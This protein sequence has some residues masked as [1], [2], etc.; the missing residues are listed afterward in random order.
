M[1][2]EAVAVDDMEHGC[3]HGAGERVAAEGRAV[4]AG[5]EAVGERLEWIGVFVLA[6]GRYG[7]EGAPVK[8]A[9]GRDDLERA[10]AV[11]CAPLAS[12]LD[13][14]LVRLRT[15]VAEEDAR[16]EG[17]LDQAAREL[18]LGLR[19]VEV[20]GVD[21]LGRLPGDRGCDVGVRVAEKV[22]GDP[23]HQVEVLA[24]GVVVEHAAAAADEGDG[25]PAPGLH[26]VAIGERGRGHDLHSP[27]ARGPRMLYPPT[28]PP[29]HPVKGGLP[30]SA[31]GPGKARSQRTPLS[32]GFLISAVRRRYGCAGRLSTQPVNDFMA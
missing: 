21:E 7:R 6:A 11:A 2:D 28:S 13:R 3:R 15:R 8:R 4:V 14:G 16:G 10:V 27:S 19:E 23:G 20:G 22:D 31:A 32:W 12:E 29:R 9:G 17:E 5:L 1:A 18:D 26:E 25:Q 24:T 30:P